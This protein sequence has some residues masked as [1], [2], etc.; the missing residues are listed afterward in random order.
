M[1]IPGEHAGPAGPL[2]D[3]AGGDSGRLLRLLQES[4]AIA[5]VGGWEYDLASDTMTWTDEQHRIHETSPA[6]YRPTLETA[7]AF[8]RPES[9]AL[10]RPVLD[11][12]LREGQ[13]YELDLEMTTAAGRRVWVH[14]LGRPRLENGR[15]VALLG[16]TQ[17][18]SERKRT[19]E[20]LRVSEA[21][22]NSLFR[23]SP[24]AIDLV[25][26]RERVCLDCNQAFVDLFGYPREAWVGHPL[27]PPGQDPWVNLEDRDRLMAGL[28]EH[29]TVL[30]FETPHRRRDGSLFMAELSVCALEIG[31][32]PC[33]LSFTRDIT[34]RKRAEEE[35]LRFSERLHQ[36]QKLE[37]LGSLTAGVAHTMN[38]VLAI[39][40]GTASIREEQVANPTDR[41]AYQLIVAAC[42]RG[43]A[44]VKSLTNFARPELACQTPLELQGLVQGML[45]LLEHLGRDRVRITVAGTGEP[46]WIRCDAGALKL[47][48]LGLCLNAVEAMAE[49]GT[50]TVR[51]GALDDGRAGVSIQD[52]G[53]GMTPEV[54][55]QAMDPFFTTKPMGAGLGLGLSMAYGV[56]RAHGGTLDINSQPAKGTTVELAFPRLAEPP[57]E[58]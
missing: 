28:R 29:G 21:K 31:G 18:I 1:N 36:A 56:V 47:A 52:D 17:D 46:L 54:L 42:Q 7:L 9:R 58:S 25:D 55:A 39:I 11:R 5:K 41:G 27:L 38:N 48:L 23:L 12:A 24:V 57:A 13:G 44:V 22:F 2:T 53:A 30:G 45:E 14:T 8:Y 32:R 50:L 4:Q 16:F 6:T 43:R 33:H 19:E 51:T 10:L 20:A 49:G 3:L 40:M 15:V 34:G 37:A 26:T 35:R